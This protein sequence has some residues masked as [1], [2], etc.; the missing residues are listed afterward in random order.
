MAFRVPTIDVSVVDLV[1]RLEKSVTY[2]DITKTLKEAAESKEYKEIMAVTEDEVVSSDWIGST[3]SSIFDTQAGIQLNP[4]FVKLVA[5]YDNEWG[6]SR[7]MCD[8]IVHIAGVDA[9]SG[10]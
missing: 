7:R 10:N 4:N 5:W 8:L 2:E 1:V 3:Y 9:K 6:Y